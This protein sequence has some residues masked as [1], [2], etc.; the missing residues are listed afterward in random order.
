M[1]IA[2]FRKIQAHLI[3][4]R[5]SSNIVHQ[6]SLVRER[7]VRLAGKKMKLM[8]WDQREVLDKETPQS[9]ENIAISSIHLCLSVYPL[10]KATQE[11]TFYNM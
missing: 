3:C 1:K 8:E 2:V 5:K 7:Q 10:L 6:S 9:N 11:R 4:V